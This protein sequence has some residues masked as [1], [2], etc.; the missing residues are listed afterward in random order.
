MNDRL[1]KQLKL[2]KQSKHRKIKKQFIAEG[3]RLVGEAINYK[4]AVDFHIILALTRI[5]SKVKCG[6]IESLK[7]TFAFLKH[8]SLVPVR[9]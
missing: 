6:F 2:L 4:S 1:I 9:L 3:R 5:K 7:T 8:W